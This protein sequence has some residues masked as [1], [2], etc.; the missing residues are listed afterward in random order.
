MDFFAVVQKRRSVRA[1]AQ[2]T[3][4]EDKLRRLLEAVNQAPSAGDLQAYEVVVVSDPDAKAALAR[5]AH[6][7]DFISEAPLVLVFCANAGRSSG[8]YGRRGADLY[9]V[10][11]A[12]I[13]AAYAQLAAVA[14]G[15]STVWVGA[16]EPS[17]VA[18]VVG[19]LKP[20]CIMPVGYPAEDPGATP[21]RPVGDLVHSDRLRA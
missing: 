10:Q 19:G 15:L 9:C 16:F 8:Q 6:G 18:R 20:V 17:A 11:D 2:K 21:R 1:Y 14:L 4:D 3:V 13:A 5:A 7:Q 12:T